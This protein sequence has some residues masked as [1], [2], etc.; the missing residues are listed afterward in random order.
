[1]PVLIRELLT[2][3]AQRGDP[4]VAAAGDALS[5]LSGLDCGAGSRRRGDGLA[6]GFGG[7]GGSR[8]LSRRMLRGV[9]R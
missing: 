9:R 7:A 5:R 2:L 6:R 8:R 3:Y 1:M 4:T